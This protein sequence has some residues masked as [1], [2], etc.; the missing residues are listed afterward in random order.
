MDTLSKAENILKTKGQ[1]SDFS[2]AKAEN[3]LKKSHL[4]RT[5]KKWK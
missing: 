2:P 5:M 3:I 1:K 4:N